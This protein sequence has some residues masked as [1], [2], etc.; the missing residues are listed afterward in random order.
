MSV[1]ARID[2]VRDEDLLDDSPPPERAA[3]AAGPSGRRQVAG[4]AIAILGLPLLT[5]LLKHLEGT[6][7]LEGEVLLYRLAVVAIAL[8]GGMW[9][10]LAS[11]VAA[12]LL[13]TFYFVEPLH[14]L[15]V[16]EPDQAV[17]L[18][19]FVVVAGVVSGAV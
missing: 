15:S 3:D 13:I 6:L 18:V 8:V 4:A 17:A 2:Y 11:A 12:A 19:V 1:S 9:V 7:S 5:L 16:A 10:A 14:T